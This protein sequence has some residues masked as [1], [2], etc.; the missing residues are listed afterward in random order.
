MSPNL[1]V[2]YGG[3]SCNC[4]NNNKLKI[5]EELYQFESGMAKLLV[6]K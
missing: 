6:T 2:R 5:V 3:Q 4:D 1:T